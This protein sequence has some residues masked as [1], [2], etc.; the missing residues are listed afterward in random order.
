MKIEIW[1][2]FVC[3][4]CYM[5]KRRLEKALEKF[6]H[7]DAVTIEYKS[8]ELDPNAEKNPGKTI[9]EL[10]A[11]KFGSTVEKAKSMNDNMAKQ[12]AELG[13][14]YNF[15]TMQHTNTLDAHRVA[16][17]AEEKDK[18]NEMTE[19]LLKAYFTD[20]KHIGDPQTLIELA[21]DVEL[22]PDAIHTLLQSDNYLA[23]VR[24]DEEEA[25]Q[26]GVQG[27]PFFVFNEKY[28]VSG[29]Q[30]TEVFTEVLAKVWEEESE[31]PALQSLTPKKS[32]TTY[33]TD[34]GC[35]EIED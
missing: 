29:A 2:D 28:A 32:K 21:G 24:A 26:I 4:F 15:D 23:K 20:S 19:R 6:S 34:D 1:S 30:P 33:C 22:D 25:K 9:H 27:V 10:M 14:V 11:K 17:Y 13:L 8:Y 3:P 31:K 7:K 5:G 35:C 16:K 18:G 12:A